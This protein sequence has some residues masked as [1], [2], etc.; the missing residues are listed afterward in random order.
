MP[1]TAAADDEPDERSVVHGSP[2]TPDIRENETKLK[3]Q[4]GNFVVV[5]IPISNPTVGTGLVAGGAYFYGQ[6]E[7]KKAVQPASVTA[8]AGFYTDTDNY[9]YGIV[10]QNYWNEN[11]WRLTGAVGYANLDLELLPNNNTGNAQDLRWLVDGAFS[12]AKIARRVG[13]HWYVGAQLR[14]VDV[15]QGL[16]SSLTGASLDSSPDIRSTGIGA[17]FEYDDRDMPINTYRGKHFH[18]EM[19]FN[20]K[21]LG[22]SNTYQSYTLG[23]SAYHELSASW[24]LAWEAEACTKVQTVPIWDACRIDL[25]GFSATSYLGRQSASAQLE[26]RWRMNRRWGF[27]GFAGAG[28]VGGTLDDVRERE[29]IPSYGIGVRFTVLPAKRI[30][31]RIDFARSTDSDAIHVAVGEAF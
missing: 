26:A 24:V 31:L 27:V 30:N 20:D 6:T 13:G 2:L 10:Q 14:Y 5:P 28:Y 11:R 29:A 18:A 21:A 7:S 25:R 17:T 19:L 15:N 16:A 4:K 3:A 9:G 23:Y 12:Y 22:S 1:H 8:A